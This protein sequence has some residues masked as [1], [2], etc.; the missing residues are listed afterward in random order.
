MWNSNDDDNNDGIP[1]GHNDDNPNNNDDLLD[2]SVTLGGNTYIGTPNFGQESEAL[3]LGANLLDPLVSTFPDA[4]FP[5]QTL[6]SFSSGSANTTT[7]VFNDVGIID[8]R[9]SI[10][11][12]SYLGMTSTE[13]DKFTS[14]SG[15]VGRF[16][17]DAFQVSV[18]NDGELENICTGFTYIGQTFSYSTRPTFTVTAVNTSGSITQNYRDGY[19]KLDSSSP[20]ID[21]SQDSTTTGTLGGP[22]LVSYTIAPPIPVANNDG[23]VSFTLGDDDFRYGPDDPLT[24]FS[25]LPNSQVAAFTADLDP[26]LSAITD[27]ETTTTGLT[28]TFDLTGNSLRFGR[29]KMD[30]VHGSELLDLVM[31]MTVEYW[32]GT[33]FLPNLL[34]SSCTLIN[35]V[36]DLMIDD[37]N[38][39]TPGASSPI[40]IDSSLPSNGITLPSPGAGVE[41][42]IDIQTDLGLSN[43][44]WLRYDW[45]SD[46]SFNDDP[47]A[48]A[49]FGIYKGNP[50]NIY[51]QQTYQ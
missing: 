51:I 45:D 11:D 46:G 21:V 37:S 32:D 44:L 50:V 47:G 14:R 49:T 1:D 39:S 4:D 31:P 34:D 25:K 17:P 8:I 42:Y 22:L 48:R 38:L 12:S 20:T 41:G 18:V 10:A 29:M 9:A 16:R 35:S 28:A 5:T 33:N 30:N 27:G 3:T 40:V 43:D 13:T 23:T 36:T 19:V 7:A 2:N 6:S 26:L 15:Y 24:A